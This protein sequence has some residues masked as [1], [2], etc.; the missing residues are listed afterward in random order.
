M[1][2]V[3]SFYPLADFLAHVGGDL[4]DLTNVTPGGVEPHDYEPTPLDVAR[5]HRARLFV[6]NG[7]G[8]DGWAD[9]LADD[10]RS[11]GVTVVDVSERLRAGTPAADEAERDRHDPHLWLD[12]QN[13]EKEVALLSD[14]LAE[15]DPS[16][17]PDYAS[18]RDAY[19]AELAAL[20]REYAAGLA[21]CRT[22]HI[23]TSHD[24]FH[25]LAK[26]YDLVPHGILGL[27]PD[28]EPSPRRIAA[29]VDLARAEKI[30][31]VFFEPLLGPRIARAVA[32]E[33]GARTLVLDPVEGLTAEELRAGESY[34]SI[35]KNN[36]ANLRTALACR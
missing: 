6:Y 23:V 1:P 22:R 12:P 2:V 4:I 11:R 15:L 10:L 34:V 3:A 24:A 17:A 16:H 8:V 18:R 33:I 21:D 32:D 7:N 36:L 19:V 14:V 35:M 9:K 20:D 27:A 28:E 13:A 25:Y 30:E 5:I 31:Y 26:R 29:L